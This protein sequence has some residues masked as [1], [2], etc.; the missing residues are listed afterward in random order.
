[1]LTRMKAVACAVVLFM[2][3]SPFGTPAA[4]SDV[5]VARIGVALSTT[6]ELAE[7][8]RKF[9]AGITLRM[10][11]FNKDAE[12]HGY[13][14]ELVFRDPESTTAGAVAA[15]TSLIEEEGVHAIIGPMSTTLMLAMVPVV[16]EKQVVLISP[17]VT[18]P[19]IG[20]N[21][22]WCFRVLFDDRFQGVALARYVRE[23]LDYSRA[24]AILNDRFGYAKS[25]FDAFRDRFIADGG[26]IVAEEHY[27]WVAD[28]DRMYD[29][30]DIFTN[31]AR[32]RPEIILLPVHSTEVAAIIRESLRPGL[33]LQFCGGATWH[34]DN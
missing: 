15:V 7:S 3:L 2:S 16:R 32:E 11:D 13:R 25:V 4:A 6:G 26:A 5:P 27:A 8:G 24:A 19:L 31:I 22:D 33:P 20:Y 10:D 34:H 29:F 18:S 12:R 17:S 21:G 23:R 9:I 28:E 30:S 14:I 1:M